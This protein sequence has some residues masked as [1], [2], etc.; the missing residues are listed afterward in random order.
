MDGRMLRPM[1]LLR[2]MIFGF[3]G[4]GGNRKVPLGI[5]MGSLGMLSMGYVSLNSLT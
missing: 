1:L 3:L 4:G 2:I 5:S